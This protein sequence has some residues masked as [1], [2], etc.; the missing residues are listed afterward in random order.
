MFY[1]SV[2]NQSR[3]RSE[4]RMEKEQLIAAIVKYLNGAALEKVRA[5]YV[6][7]VRYLR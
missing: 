4:Q 6:F 5:V 7:V 2:H 3:N 1:N